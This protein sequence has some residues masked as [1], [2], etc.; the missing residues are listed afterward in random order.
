MEQT[1]IELNGKKLIPRELTVREVEA[2][3]EGMP[4]KELHVLEDVAKDIPV[5]I[6]AVEMSVGETADNLRDLPATQVEELFR[7]VQIKNPYLARRVEALA[8]LAGQ[9]RLAELAAEE[10]KKAS[11]PSSDR[12]A[13]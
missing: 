5:P 12:S 9:I 6:E 2:L 8:E 3:I 1:T 11:N 13:D 7:Q 4:G 10:A